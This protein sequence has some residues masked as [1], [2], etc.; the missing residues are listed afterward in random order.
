MQLNIAKRTTDKKNEPKR[1]RRASKIPAVLYR[2]GETSLPIVVDGLEYDALLRKVSKGHLPTTVFTLRDEEGK[3]R[4][5]IVKEVQYH[6]T[7]YDV[8]HLDF[9]EI[10]SGERVNVKVPVVLK[11]AM[12]CQGVKLGGVLRILLRHIQINCSCDKIPSE[13]VFD[14]QNLNIGDGIQVKEAH[15]TD[16]MVALTKKSEVCVVVAKK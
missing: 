15:L 3:E 9:E 13:F 14:V 7:S 5:A 11:N 16:D 12:E 8:V 6:V 10:N 1:M 4:Q 2:K